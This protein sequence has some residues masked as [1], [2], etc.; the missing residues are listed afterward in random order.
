MYKIVLPAKSNILALDNT[1]ED[2]PKSCPI[3]HNKH[4]SGLNLSI[5]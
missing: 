3:Q 5:S 4:A 2:E 1:N